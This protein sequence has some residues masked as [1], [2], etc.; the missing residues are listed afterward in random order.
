MAHLRQW[1]IA[2]AGPANRFLKSFVMVL[3]YV[4]VVG[5]WDS[6]LLVVISRIIAASTC[7]WN[8]GGVKHLGMT[9]GNYGIR[10]QS[11]SD[12]QS[13]NRAHQIARLVRP[14]DLSWRVAGL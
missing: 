8:V 6:G 3:C 9:Y 13:V 7:M 2:G 11:R 10:L 14:A 4:P 1:W 12:E 5:V